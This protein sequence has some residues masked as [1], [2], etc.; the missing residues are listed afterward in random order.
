MLFYFSDGLLPLYGFIALLLFFAILAVPV[1]IFYWV[2]RNSGKRRTDYIVF[3]E[4][5]KWLSQI[6]AITTLIIIVYAKSKWLFE[7]DI[8]ASRLISFSMITATL[9][10]I[11]G[12]ISLPH[13]QGFAALASFFFLWF[14]I[15]LC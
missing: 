15:F 12:I 1:L 7:S 2:F 10:F 3:K 8:D 5:S 13:W 11:F 9:T 14:C 6:F 4:Y